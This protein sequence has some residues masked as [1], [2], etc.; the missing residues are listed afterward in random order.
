M[1]DLIPPPLRAPIANP[2]VVNMTAKQLANCIYTTH[3]W[4]ESLYKKM[5]DYQAEAGVPL[6]PIPLEFT[7][8]PPERPYPELPNEGLRVFFRMQCDYDNI[9]VKISNLKRQIGT[10]D[11][12]YDDDDSCMKFLEGIAAIPASLPHYSGATAIES[13]YTTL[14]KKMLAEAI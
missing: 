11:C 6:T 7:N 5:R 14:E 12:P 3:V 8:I 4:I 10:K 1:A 9:H 13:V 2:Y